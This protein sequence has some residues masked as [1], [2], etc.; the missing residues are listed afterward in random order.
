VHGFEIQEQNLKQREGSGASGQESCVAGMIR[1]SL[2]HHRVCARR[3][4]GQPL[5]KQRRPSS[6]YQQAG[7]WS[8]VPPQMLRQADNTMDSQPKFARGGP[9]G[10]GEDC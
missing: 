5:P 1:A 4:A 10:Q 6:P 2:I 7:F 3:A 8:T 9:I